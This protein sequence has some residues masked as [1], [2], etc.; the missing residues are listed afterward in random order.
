MIERFPIVQ[1]NFPI[2]IECDQ[3]QQDQM[4]SRKKILIQ[5]C[6]KGNNSKKLIDILR[7]HVV[8]IVDRL[9]RG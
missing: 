1:K 4:Y 2:R 3:P 9:R 8:E 6:L 5:Y 7:G